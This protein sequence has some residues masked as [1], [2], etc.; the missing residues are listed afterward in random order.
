MGRLSRV[1]FAP[2]LDVRRAGRNEARIALHDRELVARCFGARM[3]V[4][5]DFYA[6]ELGKRLA[7]QVLALHGE[8]NHDFGL[9]LAPAA[10]DAS[11]D[12]R[13]AELAGER[14]SRQAAH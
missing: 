7:C 5:Q 9:A 2:G 12:A 8:A 14:V 10:C 11:T 13:G 6:P 1:R 4:E 3:E